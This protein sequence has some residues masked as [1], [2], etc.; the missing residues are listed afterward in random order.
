MTAPI[1]ESDIECL[2][3]GDSLDDSGLAPLADLLR[4]LLAFGAPIPDPPPGLIAEAA[5]IA[6]SIPARSPHATSGRSRKP[7]AWR[8]APVLAAAG[9]VFVLAG[10][11]GVA[12][13]ADSSVP[14]D[15]LYGVDRA[16]ENIGI[17]NGGITERLTEAE[18]LALDGDTEAA[19]AHAGTALA[20]A[21]DERSA[22]ALQATA[23]RLR[24]V[25]SEASETVSDNVADMLEWMATTDETGRAFG[26]GV[27]ERAR[28]IGA[29]KGKSDPPSSERGNS[30]KE[31]TNG[32][33]GGIEPAGRPGNGNGPPQDI[34]PGQGGN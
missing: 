33:D 29:D 22:E 8:L 5:A 27:A 34:P 12:A 1:A 18:V 16:L 14:G 10:M 17:G 7:R 24:G 4:G 3:R 20:E 9:A 30:G 31:K 6:G 15:A 2:I 13:A 19:L 23:E 21:G 28:N 26:Q 11:T 25:G 32:N